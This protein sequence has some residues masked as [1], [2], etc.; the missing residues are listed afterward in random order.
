[1]K[2]S[3]AVG[4]HVLDLEMQYG[5]VTRWEEMGW[6]DLVKFCLESESQLSEGDG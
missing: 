1:M 3:T 4:S 6:E 5:N 2:A